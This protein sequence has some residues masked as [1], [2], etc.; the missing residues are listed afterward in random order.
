MKLIAFSSP[1]VVIVDSIF[2]GAL[3]FRL[4]LNIRGASLSHI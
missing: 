2:L 3:A 4:R 1:R